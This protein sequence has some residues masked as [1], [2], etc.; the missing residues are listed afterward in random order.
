MQKNK[1]YWII[2]LFTSILLLDML[3]LYFIYNKKP[4]AYIITQDT[5]IPLTLNAEIEKNNNISDKLYYYT[6]TPKEIKFYNLAGD[7]ILEKMGEYKVFG[8][9]SQN[10]E[11]LI[12]NN[13]SLFVV[14]LN[15]KEMNEILVAGSEIISA[16][17]SADNKIIA[18]AI[19]NNNNSEIWQ[20]N[21]DTKTNELLISIPSVSGI[22]PNLLGWGK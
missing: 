11:Y 14:N 12:S 3:I 13:K 17:V 4:S 2:L 21:L 10:G 18:Y 22:K 20:Y 8:L 7:L 19:Q 16:T 15:N 9:Y 5:A 6:Q 1:K